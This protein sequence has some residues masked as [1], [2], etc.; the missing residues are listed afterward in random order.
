MNPTFITFGNSL[1]GPGL[2]S[3]HTSYSTADVEHA[4]FYGPDRTVASPA[5]PAGAATLLVVH[6]EFFELS[7][8]PSPMPW[9]PLTPDSG[10]FGLSEPLER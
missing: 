1:G 8:E 9:S 10:L 5:T 3:V 2:E 4:V 7:E 6:G